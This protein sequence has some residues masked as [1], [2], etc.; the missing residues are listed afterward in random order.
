MDAGELLKGFERGILQADQC[1]GFFIVVVVILFYFW[2]F[3]TVT[4]RE[5]S[6]DPVVRTPCSYC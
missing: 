3:K 4:L 5:F 2:L 6:G 1:L